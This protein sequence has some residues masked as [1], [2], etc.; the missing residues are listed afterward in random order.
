MASITK[1]PRSQFWTACWRDAGGKQRRASTKTTD[2]RLARRIAEEYEKATRSK[3]TLAQL[4]KTLRAYHEELGG[5][6]LVNRS[7][8]DYLDE[9]LAEREPSISEA[10]GNFYRTVAS[11]L[12]QFF[13]DKSIAEITESDLIRFRNSLA[14]TVSP[15]TTNHYLAA[16][17]TIFASA[18]RKHRIT[19]NPAEYIEAVREFDNRNDTPRRPFTIPELQTLLATADPEWQSMVKIGLHTGCRLGDIALLRWS[20]IDLER[21][22][23]RYTARKTGKIVLIPIATPLRNHLLSLISSDDPLAPLHPRAFASMRERGAATALSSQFGELL[24]QA[25]LR[26]V[27]PDDGRRRRNPLSFHCLRHTTVSLL[28]D[29]GI[30]QATVMELVGHNSQQMSAH[31]THV[32][33]A[34]LERAGEA[35]PDL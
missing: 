32:G 26:D 9:W 22:E 3:R 21:G 11:K 7:L 1:H 14:K 31:Y 17:K 10:T 34:A 4:E 16:V 15:V 8:R 24:E 6:T 27:R 33:R 23:L 35:L 5:T 2:R 25:G 12:T 18:K 13:G 29:A 20:N 30:P 19:E 28:K